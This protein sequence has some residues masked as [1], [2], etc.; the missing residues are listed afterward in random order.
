MLLGAPSWAV[1]IIGDIIGNVGA[2]LLLSALW[3]PPVL[4]V[5]IPVSSYVIST[6]P[7]PSFLD[8]T[9]TQLTDGV[10][11]S[12]N[13]DVNP[14]G[15]VGWINA[16]GAGPNAIFITFDFGS[17]Q[18]ITAVT[19]DFLKL[20]QNF[21]FLPDSVSVGRQSFPV[22]PNAL[23]NASRG[24]LTFTPGAPL[25]TQTLQV[26][27]DRAGTGFHILID[28]VTFDG[29]V[30][31][32]PPSAPEPATLGMIGGGLLGLTIIRQRSRRT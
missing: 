8:S 1:T 25:D 2:F 20:T 13:I 22:D 10:F 23:T 9:G 14:N 21:V 12:P 19:I 4:A 6:P 18:T 30:S 5:P 7:E 15:W 27:L 17:V 16:S 29:N 31:T 24:P 26:E 11:G 32:A 3:I 28:E